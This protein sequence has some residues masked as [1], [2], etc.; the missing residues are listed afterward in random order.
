MTDRFVS[1]FTNRLDAKGRVSIPSSFRAVLA[2]D[3]YEGLYVHPALDLAAFDAGGYALRRTIDEILARFS[4]FSEE[5]ES[6][7]TALNGTSEVLRVDPEGRIMLSEAL[8]AHVGITDTV[9]FVGH[10]HKFQIWEP[11]QFQAHL[12]AAKSKLRDVKRALGAQ[13]LAP[14]GAGT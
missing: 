6:L 11:Q 9:T 1:N 3:G 10:G 5:W 2:K 14:A 4:P 13:S 8:K 12:E 7:S